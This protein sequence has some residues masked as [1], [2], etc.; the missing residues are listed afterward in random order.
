MRAISFLDGNRSVP[1]Q[2]V[3]LVASGA[4]DAPDICGAVERRPFAT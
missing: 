3:K 2:K 4:E 1:H